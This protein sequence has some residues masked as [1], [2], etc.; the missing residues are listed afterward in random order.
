MRLIK[1]R[2]MKKE[3]ER[4]S[5]I[6]GDENV[7]K[8]SKKHVAIFG[9][10]GVGSFALEAIARSNVGNI[11][12]VDFD[13]V[14]ITNI[15]RQLMATRSVIGEYKTDVL[16]KR[17]LDINPDINLNVIN[18]KYE[19]D[20][21]EEFFSDYDYIIDAIDMVSSKINLIVTARTKKIPIISAMGMGNKLNPLDIRVGSLDKTHTCPLAKTMRRELKKYNITDIKCVFSVEEPTMSKK[22]FQNKNKII[23]GSCAFVPSVAG[24][25]TA[26]EVIKDIINH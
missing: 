12:I 11:T 21:S 5:I 4:L 25:V 14:D 8:L 24:L 1:G 19:Q 17:V 26:S 16:R 15:N 22:V 23:N 20:I 6:I 9:V 2:C 18:K 13:T 7:E 3:F 10:G